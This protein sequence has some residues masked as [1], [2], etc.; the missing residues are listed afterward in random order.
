MFLKASVLASPERVLSSWWLLLPVIFFCEP[1]VTQVPKP[2]P[3]LLA[4]PLSFSH[5]A[6]FLPL[7]SSI[8]ILE[9]CVLRQVQL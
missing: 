3:F 1:H 5:F 4:P 7:S 6:P 2:L 8:S 9:T